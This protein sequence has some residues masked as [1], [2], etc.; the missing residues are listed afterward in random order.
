V[1]NYHFH[2]CSV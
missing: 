1:S 2:H